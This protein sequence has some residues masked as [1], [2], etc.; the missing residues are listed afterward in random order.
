MK[1]RGLALGTPK[2]MKLKTLIIS[3][4]IISCWNYH[5]LEGSTHGTKRMDQLKAY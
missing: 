4:K 3:L 1:G 5:Q 2:R